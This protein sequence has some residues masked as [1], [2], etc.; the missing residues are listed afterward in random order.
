MPELQRE[1][2]I[3]RVAFLE[4]QD[5][6]RLVQEGYRLL[7][8]KR[9]LLAAEIHRQSLRL[10]ALRE[11]SRGAEQA[12]RAHFIAALNCHG[13][14]E[15]SVYP[16]SP[17]DEHPL[18]VKRSRLLGLDLLDARLAAPRSQKT[19]RARAASVR[20]EPPVN[21]SPE[22]RACALAYR[23]WLA[24]LVEI[25]SCCL[26]LRRLLREYVRTERR[27]RAIE[28]IL[29][30]EIEWGL[31]QIDEQLASMDQEEIARLRHRRAGRMYDTP[32][33]RGPAAAGTIA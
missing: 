18:E 8:E 10:R 5:E 27:A 20:S 17:L 2:A 7:D 26:N 9:I 33:S 28:N 6:Q 25:A 12:A 15:L 32:G 31:R 24:L 21:P 19:A 4:L 11:Q 14:E 23:R 1:L 16:P 30:P 13:L 3:T 29:L 22:A